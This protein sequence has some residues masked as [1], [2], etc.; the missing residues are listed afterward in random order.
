MWLFKGKCTSLHRLGFVSF[1]RLS[2]LAPT[3]SSNSL[4]KATLRSTFSLLTTRPLALYQAPPDTAAL[5]KWCGI[6]APPCS[7]WS[8][9][10]FS[11][12][13]SLDQ[14]RLRAINYILEGSDGAVSGGGLNHTSSSLGKAEYRDRERCWREQ[15]APPNAQM[16]ARNHSFTSGESRG[17]RG[18]SDPRSETGGTI[19]LYILSHIPVLSFSTTEG[20]KIEEG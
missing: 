20:G 11:H 14:T 2:I 18:A 5:P 1:L 19:T 16:H 7:K 3:K 13:S 4:H 8:L 10:H 15:S 6:L 9:P 17:H 12:P